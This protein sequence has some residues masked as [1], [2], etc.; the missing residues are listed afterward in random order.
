MQS[1]T[2]LAA[3]PLELWESFWFLSGP[4]HGLAVFRILFGLYWP[5]DRPVD[6]DL[7]AVR[8]G[9][10]EDALTVRPDDVIYLLEDP[11]RV[12]RTGTPGA[13]LKQLDD[14]GICNGCTKTGIDPI[15][16]PPSDET[17]IGRFR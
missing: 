16:S 10:L 11:A 17:N 9:N 8:T 1:L 5:L 12:E 6:V 15:D 7:N 4:P 3:K 14:G 2:R 13:L